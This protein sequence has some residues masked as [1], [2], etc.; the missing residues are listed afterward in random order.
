[1]T[2]GEGRLAHASRSRSIAYGEPPRGEKL[3]KTPPAEGAQ[4]AITPTTDWKIAGTAVPKVD[5]RDF[6]TGVHRYASDMTRPG[7]LHGKILRAPAFETKLTHLETARAE[8]LPGVKVVHDG[9]FAGVVA[10]DAYTAAR[11]HAPLPATWSEPPAQPSNKTIF[12]YFK[13]KADQGEAS[14]RSEPRV[15]GS[16]DEG[17]ASANVKLTQT[18]T[19]E[20]IAH[21]PLEPRAAV[22]EWT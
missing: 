19:V 9:D 22:A 8:A 11:A 4:V 7:M 14:E 20:Y 10:P 1:L 18:Y 2:R 16:V 13:N 21:A 6:V 15:K 12:E 5:G 3:V 17:L